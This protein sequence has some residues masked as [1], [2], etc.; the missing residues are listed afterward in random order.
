[1]GRPENAGS[2][3]AQASGRNKKVHEEESVEKKGKRR[4]G[5]RRKG[6]RREG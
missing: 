1:M 5:K 3:R 6:K 2:K 4:K